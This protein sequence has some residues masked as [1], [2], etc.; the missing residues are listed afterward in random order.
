[1]KKYLIVLNFLIITF[2]VSSFCIK[3]DIQKV[4]VVNDHIDSLTFQMVKDFLCTFD[5]SCKNNSEF[6]EWS[7]ET[8][9]KVLLKA[10]IVFFQVVENGQA[11]NK[12]LIQEIENPV[13]EFDFQKIYN[14]I[15]AT[16]VKAGVK[17]TYLNAIIKASGK[18]KQRLKK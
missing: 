2:N 18:G 6:S 4:K 5:S 14:K 8:L 16:K 1:M 13:H 15:K 17:T 11:A 7:N 3:C 12:L 9:F 10:P